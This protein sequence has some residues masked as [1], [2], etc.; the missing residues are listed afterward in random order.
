MVLIELNK[1]KIRLNI[2]LQ[3]KTDELFKST[4]VKFSYFGKVICLELLFIIVIII[5]VV[6]IV[7]AFFIFISYI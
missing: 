2:F 7:V 1:I 3:N 4:S 6:V 5:V